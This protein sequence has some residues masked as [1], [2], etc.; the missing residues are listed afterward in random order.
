MQIKL[1]S[2]SLFTS[3]INSYMRINLVILKLLSQLILIIIIIYFTFIFIDC[4]LKLW[5][6]GNM[7]ILGRS[8]IVVCLPLSLSLPIK[9]KMLWIRAYPLTQNIF[10]ISIQPL[11][12]SLSIFKYSKASSLVSSISPPQQYNECHSKV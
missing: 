7:R 2:V 5:A 1:I 8:L 3:I 9:L 4:Q 10:F 11:S 12:L 6:I